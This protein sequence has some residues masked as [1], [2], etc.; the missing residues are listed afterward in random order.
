MKKILG[1]AAAVCAAVLMMCSCG[2]ELGVTLEQDE[3]PPA[4]AEGSWSVFVYMCGDSG[5]KARDAIE[6]LCGF[7]YPAN[8]NIV[9]ETG[10]EPQWDIEGISSDYLQRFVVQEGSLFLADQKQSANM[11]EYGTLSDFLSWGVNTFPAQN[12]MLVLMGD[13]TGTEMLSDKIY[14]GD[15]M[16]VEEISYAVS[17]A[18]KRFDIVAF[19]GSHGASFEMASSLSPYAG[20]MLASEEKCVGFDYER[21]AEILIEYP[22]V[23]A[24][25]LGQIMCDDYW[26][27]CTEMGYDQMAA[28]SLTDLSHISPLAQALD[29][30]ASVMASSTDGLETYGRLARNVLAAQSCAGSGDMV[31][32][33]SLAAAIAENVGEPA[34][35]VLDALSQAVI[36]NVRGGLRQSSSGLSV[37]YPQEIDEAKLNNYMT[38]MTSDNYRLFVKSITPGTNIADDYISADYRDSWAWCDYVGR[39]FSISSYMTDDSRYALAITGDMN[40]VKDVVLNRYFYYP[41]SNAYY[42]MGF[43][44]NLDCDWEGGRYMDNVTPLAPMLNGHIMQADLA[45]E[46]RDVGKIYITPVLI[47][48]EMGEVISF[49]SWESGEYEIV[50]IWQNGSPIEPGMDDRVATVHSIMEQED[51]LLTGKEFRPVFG[52]KIKNK[53]LPAGQYALEYSLEDIYSLKR[54]AVP[55][56]MEKDGSEIRIYQEQ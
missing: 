20:Y 53:S 46:I 26:A 52:L 2:R 31:D 22:Y 50:G 49:Y 12:N 15:S 39:E 40:I 33:G 32:L 38:A 10:G 5:T 4:E 13:G 6:E 51:T 16:T 54:R 1:I 55:A 8:V 34:Q 29:G 23:S 41:E 48:D 18:G 17:L 9:I 21:M 7:E 14:S 24:Q 27:K 3:K 25:E 28:M 11:G 56:Y 44:N 47:N 30:M 43:D 35:G 45:D 36:Y 37:Y 42:S 19:D